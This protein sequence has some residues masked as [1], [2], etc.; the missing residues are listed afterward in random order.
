MLYSSGDVTGIRK[1][2]HMVE[3]CD[4]HGG[5]GFKG[6]WG[7]VVVVRKCESHQG[8]VKGIKKVCQL[9][10]RCG[11]HWRGVRGYGKV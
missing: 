4:A 5:G 3:R 8:D 1:M 7:G 9:M 6:A 10:E 11:G 2:Y